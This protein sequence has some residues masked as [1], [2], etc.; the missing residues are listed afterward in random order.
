MDKCPAV[1]GLSKFD[2]CPDSDG[3]GIEDAKDACP[4]QAGP[5]RFNGCPDS[6]GD[7]VADPQDKCPNDAGPADNDGCPEPTAEVISELNEYS[8]TVLFDLISLVT[9]GRPAELGWLQLCRSAGYDFSNLGPAS[10]WRC[11]RHCTFNF[12]DTSQ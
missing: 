4:N 7:G 10:R 11:I 1:A 8:K 2:G 3:D 12:V 6:D 5:R 9:A